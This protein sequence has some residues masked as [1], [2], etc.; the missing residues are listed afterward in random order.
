MNAE[1]PRKLV[2]TITVT[3]RS[4]AW[5]AKS[6]A[7]L[8]G[9]R[10]RSRDLD[11][12]ALVVDNASGDTPE[13]RRVIDANGWQDWVTL[14]TAERNGGFAYGNNVALR[15][16]YAQPRVPD[17]FFLLNPDAEVCPGAIE[18]LVTF[19]EQD[20][21]AGM[22][23]SSIEDEN[24]ELWPWAFRFP[25]WAS[26]LEEGLSLGPVSRLLENLTV[27]RKMGGQVATQ[28]DWFPGASMMMRRQL[29]DDIG[30]MDESYFLYFEETDYLRRSKEAGWTAWYVPQS[31][32]KHVSGQSTGVTSRRERP[33]RLPGYW[34][35]SRRRYFAKNHG[36][37]YAAAVDVA[38]LM[39]YSLGAVKRA[40]RGEHSIPH[41]LRDLLSH[42]VLRKENRAVAP[43]AQFRPGQG[44]TP[45]R[46]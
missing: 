31:R 13:L 36:L 18:T 26:E 45:A 40:L 8:A 3:Y 6:L 21:K 41:F 35:E 2:L 30:G 28:V 44:P 42:S 27:R 4:A 43:T 16:A 5:T 32:V 37:P 46:G 25:S 12:R 23:A 33:A 14:I 24:G 7:A 39:A 10:A 38:A 1:T 34:F 29:V 11:V 9:E 20:P 22:A 19:L 17:Y 15:H